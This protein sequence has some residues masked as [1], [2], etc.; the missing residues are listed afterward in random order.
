VGTGNFSEIYSC[1]CKYRKQ[2][3]ALKKFLKSRLKQIN[4]EADVRMEVIK[5]QIN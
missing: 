1:V 2:K 5:F 3:F 4:K